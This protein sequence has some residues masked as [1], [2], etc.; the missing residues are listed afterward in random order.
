MTPPAC[1]RRFTFS[2]LAFVALSVGTSCDSRTRVASTFPADGQSSVD[3]RTIVAIR[4]SN[5]TTEV[6]DNLSDSGLIRVT[7]DFTASEYSGTIAL[8]QWD[9]LTLGSTVEDFNASQGGAEEGAEFDTLVFL[10][11][12]AQQ[13]K[14]GETITVFISHDVTAHGVPL[15]DSKTIRFRI[16][17]TGTST[18]SLL[19]TATNPEA[20]TAGVDLVPRI[21]ASFNRPVV[22]NSLD[23]GVAI[24][25]L[26]SG[27][28][29]DIEN[30][31]TRTQGAGVLEV[32]HRL[33]TGDAFLPGEVV[34]V[35]WSRTIQESTT[36]PAAIPEQ[37]VPR[38]LRFQV[39][40]GLVEGGWVDST[41]PPLGAT[42]LRVIAADFLPATEGVEFVA[43]T[44]TTLELYRQVAA[45]AWS[46]SSV[47]LLLDGG[48]FGD[49]TARDA[50]VLDLDR[51]G[52][53]E[54]YVLLSGDGGT[55]LVPYEVNSA[56]SLVAGNPI[57]VAVSEALAMRLVDLDVDGS[58]E[59]LLLHDAASEPLTILSR[60]ELPPDPDTID[61]LDPDSVLPIPSLARVEAAVD[62]FKPAVD[63]K[64]G[65]LN[66]NGLVDLVTLNTDGSVSLY[67][68]LSS[69]AAPVALR[70]LRDLPGVDE[71]ALGRV[72]AFEL[73]DFQSDH[74]TD[75]VVWND[76]GA[77][78]YTNAQLTIAG[79]VVAGTDLL[80][81]DLAPRRL[82]ALDAGL[83]GAS[84]A[85]A[86]EF[87]GDGA[88]DL[89]IVSDSGDVALF[90]GREDEPEQYDREDLSGV[91]ALSTDLTIA[92]VDG[93]SGLDL[94]L[95]T[96]ESRTPSLRLADEVLV[97]TSTQPSS[98]QI[99]P[100]ASAVPADPTTSLVSTI[101]DDTLRV[102]ISGTITE[103]FGG[104][105]LALEYDETLL[106]YEGFEAP[107]DFS[108][109]ASFTLCPDESLSGCSGR[110]AA[111]MRY[112]Q[113]T[114]GLPT[115]DL[116]L[117]TFVFRIP[118]VMEGESTLLRLE[119]FTDGDLEFDN[120]VAVS[121]GNALLDVPAVIVGTEL[122]V[123][124]D[125]P[126]PEDLAIECEVVERRSGDMTALISWSSPSGATFQ[127]FDVLLDG[128]NVGALAGDATS[129][130]V[131]TTKTGRLVVELSGR[132]SDGEIILATCEIIGIHAP[133]VQCSAVSTTENRVSWSLSHFAE[134]FRIYRNGRLV[135]QPLG[136][137]REFVDRSPS[138]AG[139]DLYEV[140]AV[141][142][143]EEGP[144]AP[145]EGG[146]VGDP[147]LTET[148]A[149]T[150]TRAALSART[151]SDA[152]NVL[153][154]EWANG[155]GYD[156]VS[157]ELRDSTTSQVVVAT[158]LGG[159]ATEFEYDADGAP[160][161][162][163]PGEYVA[164]LVGSV[165]GIPSTTVNS[166]TIQVP[167]PALDAG[168]TCQVTGDGDVDLSWSRVWQGYSS[169]ALAIEQRVGGVLQGAGQT[170]SLD[171]G[172]VD[173][174]LEMPTPIGEYTFELRAA[175]NGSLPPAL[176]PTPESLR[177]SCRVDF[178]AAIA[179]D[180]V[181][182]GVGLSRV[183]IPVRAQALGTLSGFS[184]ELEVP[185][186]LETRFPIELEL[187]H[188]GAVADFQVLPAASPNRRRAVV[189]VT[190]AQISPD[191][192]GDGNA[193]GDVLLA[194]IVGSVPENFGLAG[195]FDLTFVGDSQLQFAS[196]PAPTPVP[197]TNASLEVISRY[198]VVED[199][200]IPAGSSDVFDLAVF[201][202]FPE[203]VPGYRINSFTIHVRW[204]RSVLEILQVSNE[205]QA[206]SA[207]FGR[208]TYILPNEASIQTA[209]LE[210][211]AVIAWLGFNLTDPEAGL[212][213]LAPGV[214]LNVANFKFRPRSGKATA[215]ESVEVSF[216]NTGTDNP[217]A[218]FP[219]FDVPGVPDLEAF[220]PGSVQF[221]GV[222]ANPEITGLSPSTGPLLGGNELTLSGSG[223]DSLSANDFTIRFVRI[224]GPA[225]PASLDVVPSDV[226]SIASQQIR[227]RAPDSLLRPA[228]AVPTSFAAN[229]Q[230]L[231]ASGTMELVQAYAYEFPQL[232][233]I[234]R[235]TGAAAGGELVA[236]TG[237]GFAPL[238][239][240][241]FVFPNGDRLAATV[242]RVDA[243]GRRL[244]VRTPNMTG[245]EGEIADIELM[246][247][248]VTTLRLPSSF[249]VSGGGGDELAI[250][251]V[252]PS[253]GTIC[254][255]DEVIVAG[256]AFLA[257]LE[258]LFGDVPAPSVVVLD[259]QTARV[260]TPEVPEG[261]ETVGVSV[262]TDGISS[263]RLDGGF[264][265]E[266]P[267][268]A[269]VR[270]DVNG[271]EQI[272]IADTVFLSELVAGSSVDFPENLDA[273]D[274]N[275]DGVIDG[276]DV[277]AL[278][279]HLFG[280]RTTLPL[281]WP[282]LGLDPTPDFL[283]SCTTS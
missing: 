66:G 260:V 186:F 266:H 84:H 206:D 219:D 238:S 163:T 277:T 213:F 61:P 88:T 164:S 273:A 272:S 270:G 148:L 43:L 200:A 175:F 239:A 53:A 120:L 191:Q 42:P 26:H 243:D 19:V 75:I 87:D 252:T 59:V 242:D 39:E 268:P 67:Q 227:F 278:M 32:T 62:G 36:D 223:F 79:A 183:E 159:S 218:F 255:G 254:G 82:P 240:V 50:A 160:G 40:T 140:A 267:A 71:G 150:I 210:G 15:S 145:C 25:G 56:T 10:L 124:L 217:T 51:D 7:G 208:G 29:L 18:L 129:T 189:E 275:D 46:S 9:G 83:S 279:E 94:V 101:V 172:A 151:S 241:T 262:R 229:V 171:L 65:D 235:S 100:L 249:T 222:A 74:D 161:G 246:V 136:A 41:A 58:A 48:D 110:A 224:E 108:T 8:A 21:G 52:E 130:D 198:V 64:S 128:E 154:L 81:S 166:N 211:D 228:S 13:F 214:L 179:V 216:V 156:S 85:A 44:P 20:L 167:V 34:E 201:A 4:L 2:L 258:V 14:E 185:A 181:S 123:A 194:T 253:N 176:Q 97:P 99:A 146:P 27:L 236:L 234:D 91:G 63:I 192:D 144:R 60:V 225:S 24:R 37:L 197:E 1:I 182:T 135:S 257:S 158:V 142:G 134:S 107:L 162:V 119:G 112:N 104:Y 269:F 202:T 282:D 5:T 127:S 3:P 115:N 106:T 187:D 90:L 6:D 23:A 96:P 188:V 170:V 138:P 38:L 220:F 137:S 281:P 12:E 248:S 122:E 72:H 259:A 184:F 143:S 215:G 16:R 133:Q 45:A 226:M 118:E 131:I 69:G 33:A 109:I 76:A 207:V 149:P 78:V 153:R 274:V 35:A 155:E 195:S 73:F 233:A 174:R 102:V 54:V 196:E 264:T 256:R 68:N 47:D 169:L 28:R 203:T 280:G 93:N 105:S 168:L 113:N 125:P 116:E 17:E 212:D 98:F 209:N 89:V 121:E 173:F 11:D 103:N 70:T 204:D 265:F 95:L 251:S 132:R 165:G 244:L 92:D 180:E 261:T 263:V 271:D 117:G 141:I 205:D 230:F 147:D 276:G 232:V 199:V 193:D 178:D 57:D 139:S 30:A 221:T 237:A 245:H 111:T 22:G 55:R 190:G 231:S 49:V 177:R 31:F 157:V 283:T 86:M 152:P 114:R 247:P 250:V 77:L 126:P 80:S